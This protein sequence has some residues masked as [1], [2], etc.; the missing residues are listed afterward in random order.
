MISGVTV[1]AAFLDE[2]G[3]GTAFVFCFAIT[4]KSGVKKHYFI[5]A[6]YCMNCRK[7]FKDLNTKVQVTVLLTAVRSGS[8]NQF[9]FAWS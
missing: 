4:T 6:C 8:N 5:P 1:T 9:Y 7:C 3:F 2:L